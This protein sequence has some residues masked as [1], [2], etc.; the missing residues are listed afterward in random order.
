MTSYNML[1]APDFS[2]EHFAGWHLFNTLLQK[3]AKLN[4]RLNMPTSHSEQN[5]LIDSADIQVIYANPFDATTLIREQGYRAIARPCGKPDEMVIVSSQKGAVQALEDLT[6]G[7]TIA[8]TN[9]RDVK[10]IGLRLLEAVDLLED[11]LNWAI[12]ESYQAAARQVL[13]GEAA[14]AFF[15]SET[16]HNF[17]RLTKSQ[18]NVLIESDLDAIS[19]VLLIKDNCPD[20]QLLTDVLLSLGQ[21][22][23]S[24][25]ALSELGMP[26]G[27]EA[28]SEE[29]A[30]FMLDLMETL[31]S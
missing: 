23:D 13:K 31:L 19:H 6:A 29:D 28:M 24:K 10:L 4:M 12:T 2:P 20:A 18:L 17:S 26:D 27:F 11:D 7:S 22:A 25:E 1:I 14:A 30:E 8:M 16:Y 5:E 15:L 9:N 3:R 21:D